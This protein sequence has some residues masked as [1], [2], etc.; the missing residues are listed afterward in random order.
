MTMQ[1]NPII[2]VIIVLVILSL[3][4]VSCWLFWIFGIRKGYNNCL[5]KIREKK[6]AKRNSFRNNDIRVL[7][8]EE[9][10]KLP[11]NYSKRLFKQEICNRN[12]EVI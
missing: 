9:T 10:Y 5:T 7:K 2:L 11:T 6:R 1:I 4:I 3:W 8:P 12:K